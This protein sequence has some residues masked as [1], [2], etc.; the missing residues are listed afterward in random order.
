MLT[1][2]ARQTRE[3][4]ET[5]L[6]WFAAT[7]RPLPWRQ[8]RTLYGTWI[9]EIMLQQTTVTVV[10]P[11]W[12]RFM[13][14]FPDVQTL[15]AADEQ[16]VLALWSGLGYY[17]RARHLHQAARIISAGGPRWPATQKEWR[18][19]PGIG[20]YASGAIVSQ[21]LGLRVAA[22]DANARRVLTRWLVDDPQNLGEMK[23]A[24]LER[25][26]LSLVPG[27]A[28]GN[29]NEALMELGAL[30]CKARLAACSDCPVLHLCRA[31]LAGT[32]DQIPAR[33]KPTQT[34]GALV[35]VLVIR[36][37]R[38]TFL[39]RPGSPPLLTFAGQPRPVRQDLLGLHLGLWG[40]PS[41]IWV[42]P[43]SIEE[44]PGFKVSPELV[45]WLHRIGNSNLVLDSHGVKEVGQFNH[46]ITRYRLR[47][48]VY[49]A[50]LPEKVKT[51]DAVKDIALNG[52][53]DYFSNKD[54]FILSS[55]QEAV[56]SFTRNPLEQP[57]SNLVGKALEVVEESFG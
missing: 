3:L 42:Q 43:D 53:S 4:Q 29:W 9:A 56:G 33:A 54:I 52:Y 22:V 41:T 37:G 19:L 7:K 49:L 24:Q 30:I 11:Y 10:V 50:C 32:A 31:G 12:L 5:L 27:D 18:E 23:P 44:S 36:R 39:T 34:I 2:T 47:V 8:D 55:S 46:A 1:L 57:I 28:P 26:A 40:L 13:E 16:E 14:R 15:A 20:P 48:R 21:A 45:S 17:R 38:Q 51:A 25:L 6:E 35:G